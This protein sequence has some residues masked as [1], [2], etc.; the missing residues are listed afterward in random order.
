MKLLQELLTLSEG[1]F[2]GTKIVKGKAVYE[3]GRTFTIKNDNIKPRGAPEDKARAFDKVNPKTGARPNRSVLK[4][5]EK[6]AEEFFGIQ[7]EETDEYHMCLVMSHKNGEHSNYYGVNVLFYPGGK[8]EGVTADPMADKE[9]KSSRGKIIKAARDF[10][11]ENGRND[12]DHDEHDYHGYH[13]PKTNEGMSDAKRLAGQDVEA[14]IKIKN[15][16]K[17]LRAALANGEDVKAK[18]EAAK[19]KLEKLTEGQ[20]LLKKKPKQIDYKQ[21]HKFAAEVGK[22]VKS[23]Y[24]LDDG[25]DLCFNLVERGDIDM[26]AGADK[27]AQVVASRLTQR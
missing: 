1:G 4:K 25:D 27:A 10:V 16:I 15:E 22:L 17:K 6:N 5:M 18:L 21:A 14:I 23:K 26:D 3:A 13:D 9:W 12:N 19:K 7:S 20:F 11:K 8:V 24:R 2:A